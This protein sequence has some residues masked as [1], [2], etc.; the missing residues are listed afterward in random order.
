M[1]RPTLLFSFSL[2]SSPFLVSA[3]TLETSNSSSWWSGP[4]GP[5]QTFHSSS[6]EPPEFNRITYEEESVQGENYTL[7]S[8]RGTGTGQP[9]PVVMDVNGSLVWSG[10][11]DGYTNTMDLRVQTYKGEEVLTFFTGSFFSGGYANGTWQIL[12]NNYTNIKQVFSLNQTSATS[13]FHEFVITEN[14]TALVESWRLREAD[15]T[16][17]GG[18]G[19]GWTWTCVLQEIDISGEEDELLFEWNSIDAGVAPDESYFTV[20]GGAGNSSDNPFDSC[21]INTVDKFVATDGTPLYLTSLRGPS[22]IYLINGTSGEIVWRL[23]GKKTDFTMGTNATFWYQHDARLA[24]GSDINASKFNISLFDN[25]A[26]GGEPAESMARAIVLELDTNAMTAEL[27]WE[28]FPSFETVAA[29]QGSHRIDGVTG[30]HVVGWGATPYFTEYDAD[31][32]IVLDVAFGTTASVVQSYRAFR[33]TWTGYP[34]TLPSLAVNASN[35]YAS[36]NGATEV[37]SWVLMGGSSETGAT[38]VVNNATKSG[39]E[40]IVGEVGEYAYLA[41]AAMGSDSTCLGVSAVY[42]TSSMFSTSTNGTCPSGTTVA[43]AGTNGTSTGSSISSGSSSD[44]S[45][46]AGRT[47][48]GVVGA[49]LAVVGAAAMMV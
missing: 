11:E 40:T 13:D 28:A 14:D 37:A 1:L 3:D 17:A 16:D 38:T 18:N 49:V 23:S 9:A 44:G 48:V 34:L 41:V 8:Y 36:W 21:H 43:A 26:G 5:V 27:V 20:S 24:P 22:T 25:A 42:S 19:T 39:F 45:S 46:A 7:I 33:Q 12:S 30:H 29:S 47:H 32:N 31:A 6:L 4:V 35:A 10:A 15:L 2:L